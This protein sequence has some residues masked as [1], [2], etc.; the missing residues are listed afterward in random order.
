M[1]FTAQAQDAV[2]SAL[3]AYALTATA[4][5][6]VLKTAASAPGGGQRRFQMCDP[7]IIY[8]TNS[9]F[10]KPQLFTLTEISFR[11]HIQYW[12]GSLK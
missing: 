11:D 4:A 8:W 3:N 9:G 5:A 10:H 1:F 7:S 6:A 2:S 12:D